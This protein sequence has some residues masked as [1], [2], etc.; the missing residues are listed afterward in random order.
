M[1]KAGIIMNKTIKKSIILS[2]VIILLVSFLSSANRGMI[3]VGP[4]EVNLQESGQNAIVAWNGKEE[5][6]ILS[7]DVK[8]SES[9][10]VLEVLPLPSNPIRVKE[11]SFDSFKKVT[12]IINK[13][14]RAI[15]EELAREP[16]ISG[17]EITF[18]KKMGPHDVTIVKVNDVDYFINWI[19]DFTKNKGFK[20]TKISPEFKNSIIS[21]LNRG[22]RFFVFDVIEA[23]KDKQ[24]IN[25]LIYRF[26]TDFLYYPLEITATSDAGRSNSNINIFLITKGMI[27]EDIV[28]M[29]GL[30]PKIGFAHKIML[31]KGELKEVSPE[32]E[33]LF[34]SGAFVMNASYHGSLKRLNRDL[35]YS[36]NM[37]KARQLFEKAMDA[38]DLSEKESFYIKALELWPSYPEAHNNLGD[39][40]EKQG[41]FKEAIK[42]Y[43]IA[44]ALAPNAPYPYFGLGDVYFKL[45]NYKLAITYYE[46]GLKIEP[47]DKAS[48]ERL[49]LSRILTTKILFP[50]DSYKL[51][52]EAKEQLKIIAEALSSP[53]L[54]NCVFEIQGH[55][56]S[57]GP[58]GYNLRLSL[59]RAETVKKFLIERCQINKNRLTVKG[60]GEDRPI[61][62]NE[63]SKG[64]Q[65]NRRV[66]IEKVGVRVGSITIINRST[67][68][69]KFETR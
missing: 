61:A 7:T 67:L 11:G 47:D 28:E 2:L 36:A 33:D 44:S 5:V 58:A 69:K 8:S 32:I 50:F 64:R 48:L 4:K 26:K 29:Q 53:E 34:K 39:V 46:R 13:K 41:R 15:R 35:V 62:S 18:H 60:Y 14:V 37:E 52:E 16:G 55:T 45:G 66:E 54:K 3:I 1:K 51:T 38:K 23:R 25:P 43:E 30:W 22:I 21:Y 20:Y 19:K 24:S 68:S 59:R 49:K 12:E 9:S 31:T 57:I 10:L 17:V 27:D 56:D 63:I 6:L 42:E 40:Y 65:M